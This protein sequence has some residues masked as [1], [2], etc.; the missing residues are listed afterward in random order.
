MK[1]PTRELMRAAASLAIVAIVAGCAARPAPDFWGRWR[2]VNRYAEQ[3]QPIPLQQQYLFYASPLD[4]TLKA[5]LTR[6]TKD[7]KMTLSYQHPSDFTLHAAVAGIRTSDLGSA[8]LQLSQ[9][10]APQQ[11]AVVVE[12]NQIVVRASSI[13]VGASHER[14][15]PVGGNAARS[16]SR[17]RTGG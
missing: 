17:D 3:P 5:L 8:A 15:D 9:A 11:V 4:G 1:N 16:P 2:P 14:G 6:W 7:A 10:Y 13:Q 12:G